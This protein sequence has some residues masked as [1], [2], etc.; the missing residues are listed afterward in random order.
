MNKT[1][2][3]KYAMLTLAII[4]IADLIYTVS[5]IHAWNSLGIDGINKEL[6]IICRNIMQN[7]GI[8]VWIILKCMTSLT[9]L[10]FLKVPS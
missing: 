5:A 7:Y 3:I 8:S 9:C 10:L 6:N 4:N 2:T 1:K